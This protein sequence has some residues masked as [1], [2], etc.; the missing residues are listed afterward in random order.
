ME[1]L[2][3]R[4]LNVSI[5]SVFLVSAIIIYRIFAKESPKW[6]SVL[7]WGLVGARL[8]FPFN[9]ESALSEDEAQIFRRGKNSSH[10]NIPKSASALEYK[11]ATGFEAIFGYL[12]LCGKNERILELFNLAYP[13]LNLN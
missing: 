11:T 5:A 12:H 9:I 2:F 10:L 13:E 3:V 4:A 7:L 1:G 8:I 6:V